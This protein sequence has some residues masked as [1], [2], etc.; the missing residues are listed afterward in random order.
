MAVKKLIFLPSY[1]SLLPALGVIETN[2]KGENT[3]IVSDI[4]LYHYL[5]STT[6]PSCFIQYVDL[7]VP[8]FSKNPFYYLKLY[9]KFRR[10]YEK[11]FSQI[12]DYDIYFFVKLW[13]EFGLLLIKKL[14]K[15]NHV[16]Y[17]DCYPENNFS[18]TM[19]NKLKEFILQKIYGLEM[20]VYSIGFEIS[21]IQ[22]TFFERNAIEVLDNMPASGNVC[23]ILGLDNISEDIRN[24]KVL[25]LLGGVE[26]VKGVNEKCIA[27]SWESIINVLKETYNDNEILV[28]EHPRFNTKIKVL[29]KYI[30]EGI[31]IIPAEVLQVS[32]NFDK[33]ISIFSTALFGTYSKH[34]D[35]ISVIDLFELPENIVRHF[36]YH[37]KTHRN[38]A[39]PQNLNKLKSIISRRDL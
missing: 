7:N 39:I 21:E 13:F 36:R 28:K 1:T 22:N 19:H 15:N 32:Y 25:I 11:Y 6:M 23:S 4:N 30:L 5:K 12:T 29:N 35:L 3:L 14:A 9:S 2:R 27:K 18:A 10:V 16:Y 26:Y 38:I 31:R 34:T 33:I 24:K 17:Y 37:L 20:N 8:V